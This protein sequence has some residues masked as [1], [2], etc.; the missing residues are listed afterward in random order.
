[1]VFLFAGIDL[2]KMGAEASFSLD[3]MQVDWIPLVLDL[4]VV[5]VTIMQQSYLSGSTWFFYP[6][7]DGGTFLLVDQWCLP[8]WVV[9]VADMV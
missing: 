2:V 4:I 3:E 1:M 7:W 6:H 5:Q 9:C 8:L